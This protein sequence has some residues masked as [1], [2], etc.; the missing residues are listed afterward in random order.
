MLP[1]NNNSAKGCTPQSSSCVIWNGPDLPCINLC[2]GDT[3]DEILFQIATELCEVLDILNLD[4]YD[5]VPTD[6]DD[7]QGLIQAII[8]VLNQQNPDIP[9]TPGTETCTCPVT[10]ADCFQYQNQFGDTITELPL[11]DYARLIAERIC[12]L[13]D[14]VDTNSTAIIQLNATTENLQN[15]IDAIIIN[16]GEVQYYSNITNTTGPLSEGVRSIEDLLLDLINATGNSG[17]I[18]QAMLASGANINTADRC[19][20]LGIMSSIP[21]WVTSPASLADSF[22]NMWLAVLDLKS[23]CGDC[24][25]GGGTG[26]S[27]ITLNFRAVLETGGSDLSLYLDGSTIPSGF[28]D[29]SPLGSSVTIMDNLGNNT[30]VNLNIIT[31]S[32]T[33]AGQTFDLD[34]TPINTTADLTITLNSCLYNPLTQ[35]TCEKTYTYYIYPSLACPNMTINALPDGAILA[36]TSLNI[37]TTYI[38]KTYVSGSAVATQTTNFP[39]AA[40]TE[41]ITLSGL[42]I[43][44]AY[45]VEVTVA[46]ANGN[47]MT[48]PR[49]TFTTMFVSCQPPTVNNA[50]LVILP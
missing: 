12:D 41:N 15:Q 9:V 49:Q 35:T 39:A 32:N 47:M 36:F 24:C 40:A 6:I 42:P 27:G 16:N 21:G 18:Y 25:D 7:M 4:N 30:T 44:T 37:G 13:I 34:V 31:T 2:K 14:Q 5:D 20:G 29:C 50:T 8:N 19:D 45:D 1:T 23:T 28:Q 22:N 43:N 38:V 46:G 3:I 26:C 33:P 11:I 48:C 17:D 10:L